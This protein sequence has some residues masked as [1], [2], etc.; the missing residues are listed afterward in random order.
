[1]TKGYDKLWEFGPIM[2]F[3]ILT[4]LLGCV[5]PA[6]VAAAVVTIGRGNLLS[7]PHPLGGRRVAVAS[8]AEAGMMEEAIARGREGNAPSILSHTHPFLHSFVHALELNLKD[9]LV[10][11]YQN[12]NAAGP[13]RDNSNYSNQHFR[14]QK[15]PLRMELSR[16]LR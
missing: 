10:C 6:V 14:T 13:R 9:A 5:H 4:Y 16:C 1:M 8:P 2:Y 7:L 11:Y 15:V 3:G 12:L